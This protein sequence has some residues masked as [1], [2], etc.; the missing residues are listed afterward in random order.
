ML[1]IIIGALALSRTQDFIFLTAILADNI[2]YIFNNRYKI[3][4]LKTFFIGNLLLVLGI[5]IAFSPQLLS[6]Q[7]MYGDFFHMPYT[8]GNEGFN[9]VKPHIV[10]VLINQKTGLFIWTPIYAFM[11]FGLFILFKKNRLLSL[12]S[13]MIFTIQFY[14][15]S[16]WSGWSQGE[17]F[18]IRMLIS[19]LPFLSLGLASL[20]E[21]IYKKFGKITLITFSIILILFNFYSILN[22]MLF[23]KSPTY[24]RG[25]NTREI[26]IQKIN[27]DFKIIR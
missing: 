24:D 17:S 20:F 14:L 5:I 1:G 3:V 19:T 2:S 26:I 27:E 4:T 21:S 15:I 13:L 8:A 12:Y 11:I 22:F 7:I 6:W 10:N 18:S 23:V 16:S 9:L 25:I